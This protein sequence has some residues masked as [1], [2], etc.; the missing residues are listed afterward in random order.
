MALT[1][2][3]FANFAAALTDLMRSLN[4]PPPAFV[5]EGGYD[6]TAL[7]ESVAATM[8]AVEDPS[9]FALGVGAATREIEEARDALRPYWRL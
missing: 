4:A 1:A 3:S 5:L 2:G 7:T 9:S 6:L 8:Q